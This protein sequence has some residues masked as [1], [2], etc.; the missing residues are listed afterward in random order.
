MRQIP[1]RTDFGIRAER[2]INRTVAVR[3]PK[4]LVVYKNKDPTVKRIVVLQR[5]TA[6][7]FD[8]LLDYLSQVMQF[9]V[10][11]LFSADGRRVKN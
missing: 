2:M 11:K 1:R 10:V 6:P 9:P 7:S 3:T 4:R 5:R 8:A